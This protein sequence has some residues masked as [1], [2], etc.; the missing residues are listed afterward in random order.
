MRLKIA[1]LYYGAVPSHYNVRVSVLSRGGCGYL[2]CNCILVLPVF[3][4]GGGMDVMTHIFR[5]TVSKFSLVCYDSKWSVSYNVS[6][7]GH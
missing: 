7:S 3:G 2:D 6:V 1:E 4:F 5:E